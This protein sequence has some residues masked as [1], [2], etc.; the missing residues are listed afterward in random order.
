MLRFRRS[1]AASLGAAL[2]LTCHVEARAN[3]AAASSP[4]IVPSREFLPFARSAQSAWG[5]ARKRS[6]VQARK[7]ELDVLFQQKTAAAPLKPGSPEAARFEAKRA[8]L[9]GVLSAER[10]AIENLQSSAVSNDDRFFAGNMLIEF[11]GFT[12]DNG[13]L[14]RGLELALASG[15]VAPDKR[16][17]FNFA[18]GQIDYDNKDLLSARARF[19]EL[20]GAGFFENDIDFYLAES[21]FTESPDKNVL[22]GLKVLLFYSE[23]AK[24][25]GKSLSLQAMRRGLAQSYKIHDSLL[26]SYFGA[27]A[28]RLEPNRKNWAAAVAVLRISLEAEGADRQVMVD[29]ARL[30]DRTA[31][32]WEARDYLESVRV[33]T[34]AALPKELLGAVQTGTAAGLLKAT[35]PLVSSAHQWARQ[36][37]AQD[38]ASNAFELANRDARK[39]SARTATIVSAGSLALSYGRPDLAEELYRIA[40]A[41]PDANADLINTRLGIAQFDLGRFAEAQ[42]SFARVT[43]GGAPLARLWAVHAANR[44][45]GL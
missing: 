27:E 2:V 38:Q 16:P 40:Q 10:A 34:A 41:R 19:K 20:M 22:E 8:E 18:L 36:Q 21:Y 25:Q 45:K 28:A 26:A 13:L 24:A 9:L 33:Y 43:G 39:A 7:A 44:Q 6:D 15:L 29:L 31:G 11:G 35:D 37:L 12:R 4:K 32:F 5:E 42:A 1:I 30:A 14:R 17:R 3:Q 23:R